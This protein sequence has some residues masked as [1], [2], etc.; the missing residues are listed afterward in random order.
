MDYY[1]SEYRRQ[2]CQER[3]DRIRDDYR[4]AQRRPTDSQRRSRIIVRMK[5]IWQ[6]VRRQVPQRA[7]AY[8]S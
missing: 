3:I 7:P 5:S 1:D 6:H 2:Y 8:R 4:R